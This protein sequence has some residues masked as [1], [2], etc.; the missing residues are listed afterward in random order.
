MIRTPDR[1]QSKIPDLK[2]MLEKAM[3]AMEQVGHPVGS[4]SLRIVLSSLYN[5]INIHNLRRAQGVQISACPLNNSC[6]WCRFLLF[7]RFVLAVQKCEGKQSCF[8]IFCAHMIGLGSRS[9]AYLSPFYVLLYSTCLRFISFLESVT[10]GYWFHMLCFLLQ[11]KLKPPDVFISY[12][13]QNS[14]QAE[15]K[16]TVIKNRKSLGAVDPRDIKDFLTE[17]KINCW[18]DIERIGTVSVHSTTKI[19]F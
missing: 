12:C 13:W 1:Y 10:L 7:K 19:H 8:Y 6:M 9:T 4:R 14:K 17:K 2:D 15:S 11:N 3:I 18:L 16:N 5:V